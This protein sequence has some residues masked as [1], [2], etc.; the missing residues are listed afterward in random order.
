MS[1][2]D[3]VGVGIIASSGINMNLDELSLAIENRIPDIRVKAKVSVP[4][5][6]Q[7]FAW[8]SAEP[9]SVAG[10]QTFYFCN[11]RF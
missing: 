3:M 8:S 5:T 10:V 4:A 11:F 2:T 7:L 9:R 1:D 6:E